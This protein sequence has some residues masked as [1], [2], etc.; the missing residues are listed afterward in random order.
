MQ[1]YIGVK[2]I[3]AEPMT[4]HDFTKTTSRFCSL[5]PEPLEGYRVVYPDGYVSWSPKDAFKAYRPISAMTFGLAIEAMKKGYR[6][7]RKGW[8]GKGMHLFLMYGKSIQSRFTECYGNGIAE[9]TP[10]VADSICMYTA[11]K[12]VA[13]G[14]LASQT[15]M[16]AEDWMI[17][18]G[19][20]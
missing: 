11:Q 7:A 16:L 14:W 20:D 10:V 3:E 6:V 19:V 15:D 18:D 8:N 1:Q 17:V 9:E 5:G 13:V 2:I 12:T 4:D